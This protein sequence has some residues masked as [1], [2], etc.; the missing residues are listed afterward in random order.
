MSKINTHMPAVNSLYHLDQNMRGMEKAMERIASGKRINNAGDDAAGAAIVNRMTSQIRGLENAI[1]NA[2]DAISMSQT[3]EGAL[4]EVTDIL[5]RMRELSVQGA[6][7]SYSGADRQSLNAE[8]VELQKE[9]QRIAETTYFN[10]T[11]LLN[12]TF[13]DTNFQIGHQDEHSHTLTIEDVRPTALGQYE[14]FTSQTG[15]SA[16]EPVT[17][18]TAFNSN[19]SRIADDENITIYGHV[20]STT[21][22][23]K[24][25]Q[26]AKSIAETVTATFDETGVKANAE[27]RV[28]LSLNKI[29]AAMSGTM[30][31]KL[32]G[33]NSVAEDVT[34]IVDFGSTTTISNLTELRNSI[35][36]KTGKTGIHATL[37]NDLES[38]D[39]FSP[40]GYTIGINEFDIVTIG[41]GQTHPSLSV[42]ALDKDLNVVGAPAV[43][44]DKSSQ[45]TRMVITLSDPLAYGGTDDAAIMG[46]TVDLSGNTSLE[47][48]IASINT[49]MAAAGLDVF[50]SNDGSDPA[51]LLIR[52][53]SGAN[54]TANDGATGSLFATV[55]DGG[56][57]ALA[58]A[59]NVFTAT[60]KTASNDSC[61]VAGVIKF[62]SSQIFSVHTATPISDAGVGN[63]GLFIN[64]PGAASINKLSDG[65]ILTIRNAQDFLG[66]IDAS[67]KRIDAERGDLGATINR[68][69]YTINNL[70]NVVMNSK[71]AKSRIYDSDIAKET[72][73]LTKSQ[74]LQQAAQAMLAQANSTAQNILSLLRN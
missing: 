20:G 13:Q 6:S 50:A 46:E 58:A 10:D 69:E 39:L 59:A 55:K 27:T 19:S 17:S 25:G 43:V 28:R 66:V 8:I 63:A 18:T 42:Q 14:I 70:S 71:A 62:T 37:S 34:A 33:M 15:F 22:D 61:Q 26:S 48:T 2:A 74:I 64:S 21:I 67:L 24:A 45:E 41:D 56:G 12:G 29:T 4:N 5:Q 31:F 11:L 7:G 16:A 9:L 49:A 47:D 35:N 51:N 72:S 1:R 30:T 57:N 40:D 53:L 36:A 23:I 52:S 44:G 32:L 38:I 3:A 65:D 73:N 54:I 68:M 60:A